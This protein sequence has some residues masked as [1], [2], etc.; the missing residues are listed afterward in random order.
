[1][2]AVARIRQAL[3]AL[4]IV[5][6]VGV[7]GHH[8]LTKQS[9]IDS[10]Y[11]FVIT[12]SGVGYSEKSEVG[13]G[14]QV[15]SILIILFGMLAVGY[16]ISLLLTMMIE[17]QLERALG[18]RRMTREIEELSGHTVICGFGR[19]GKTLADEFN[20]RGVQFVVVDQSS[21][22]AIAARAEGM[23]VI[24]GD[25]LDEE[26][27]IAAGVERAECFV[28]SLKSDADNVFVTL[29]ARNLCPEIRIIARGELPSTEKKLRQAGADQVVLP[30]VIG[31]RRM[32][33]LV[34]RPHAAEMIELV[35]DHKA[36]DAELE[37]L[38]IGSDSPLA[39]Q[40]IREV[41]LREKHH[42]L[43]IAIRRDDGTMEFA[44]G[45]GTAFAAGDTIIV[46]GKPGDL[47]NFQQ[48]NRL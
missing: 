24:T 33:A 44:P 25:A 43:I 17:G 1:M 7:V 28:A 34:T 46:M 5:F 13:P 21:D 3:F 36:L 32:A 18:I 38:T 16:A 40:T 37:E 45:A 8:A 29:T 41:A 14:L 27:L 35:T 2:T 30:A 42:M 6:V 10:V 22:I 47:K 9:W 23:L 12:V 4:A 19:M 11:Y 39:G 31:A 15:F 48:I 26:T 20:R